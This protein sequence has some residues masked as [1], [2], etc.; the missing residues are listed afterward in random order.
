MQ[1]K[2]KAINV[3]TLEHDEYALVDIY[4]PGDIPC[5]IFPD[6]VV[7]HNRIFV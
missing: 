7:A 5:Q 4:E 2:E 3:Y 6:L 1:P